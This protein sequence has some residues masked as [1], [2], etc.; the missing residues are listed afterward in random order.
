M[1]KKLQ[2]FIS[3]T[4]TDLIDERQKSVN[5][6]LD[7]G[8]IPV[9]MELFKAGK[10]QMKTIHKWID[11]SDVY[12]LILGGRYGS[13][14]DKTKLSYTQLEYEYALS[15]NMPVFAIVL[16][17]TYLFAK[18][19]CM[20]R[21]TIFENDNVDKYNIF[22]EEVKSNV[23]L[24]VKNIEEIA[25]KIHSQLNDILNDPDYSLTGWVR[26][27]SN[28]QADIKNLRKLFELLVYLRNINSNADKILHDQ[29]HLEVC[30]KN[31]SFYIQE[32]HKF[33]INN[34]SSLLKYNDG[35]EEIF[36]NHQKI[37][38]GLGILSESQKTTRKTNGKQIYNYF[39][40][41]Y[42]V[43][44]TLLDVCDYDIVEHL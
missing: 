3:S 14:E 31:I 24:F 30:S 9:G 21:N 37:L 44:S 22:K 17:D 2:V 34:R 11:E 35:L 36:L 6:I 20:G 26:N 41:I 32:V 42:N 39:I 15:K 27:K 4:H 25:T 43:S 38:S 1:N 5:T 19:A 7:T 8:H 18:A 33:Y 23:V 29:N 28:K 40:S 12:M 10:P 16:E 13:I